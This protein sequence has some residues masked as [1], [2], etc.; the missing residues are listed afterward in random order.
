[1]KTRH[2][3][4][5]LALLVVALVVGACS[6]ATEV[7]KANEPAE[8]ELQS[9]A[10]DPTFDA[11]YNHLTPHP[12]VQPAT[13][14]QT[15]EAAVSADLLVFPRAGNDDVAAWEPGRVIV[16]GPATGARTRNPFGFARRV[17]TVTVEPERILVRTESLM[18]EDVVQGD[19]QIAVQPD[20]ARAAD[21]SNVNLDEV[22]AALYQ[23]P[24]VIAVPDDELV[25]DAPDA[26]DPYEGIGIETFGPEEGVRPQ[27]L[28][29]FWSSVKKGAQAVGKSIGG[30][31]KAVAQKAKDVWVAVTPSH[32]KG[33]VSINRELGFD[34][35]AALFELSY[36]KAFRSKSKTPFE[37]FISGSG[38]LDKASIAFNPGFQL[39]AKIPVPGHNASSQYWMN[40]DTRL[41]LELGLQMSVEAG[42]RSVDNQPVKHQNAYDLGQAG[43]EALSAAREKLLGD[44]DLKPVG[45]WKRTLYISQPRVYTFTAGPV[46]V[47]ITNTVQ[48]D[49]ECGFEVKAQ[50]NAKLS[51]RQDARFK[52]SV[53]YDGGTKRT[54]STGPTF[55]Q[56]RRFEVQVTGG[57][58]AVIACGLIPRINVFAYDTLGIFAGVRG[59]LVA[60][61]SYTEQCKQDPVKSRPDGTVKLSLA[62][63]VGLQVGA[64]IQ[65]PGSSFFGKAGQKAGTDI[66]P[67]EPWNKEWELLS[68]SWTFDGLGYCTPACKNL[69]KDAAESDVDCGGPCSQCAVGKRCRR[70][71]DCA[72]A[73]CDLGKCAV[74]TCSDG[75]RDG[76]ETDV[77][78]GGPCAKCID[79]RGCRT[80]TDCTSSFCALPAAGSGFA[81]GTCT[82]NHCTTGVQ[83]AD[84]AG[85][86]CGGRD[87]PKCPTG[88]LSRDPGACASGFWDGAYCVDSACRD[89]RL[90][91][92]EVGVDCGGVCA[93][94]CQLGQACAIDADCG[95]A[96][97]VCHGTTRTCSAEPAACR[98]GALSPGEAAVDCGAACKQRCAVESPCNVDGDCA[99]GQCHATSRTC[100]SDAC[101]NGRLD[102][103]SESDVDCGGFCPGRCNLGQRCRVDADCN[104][105]ACRAGVC[106]SPQ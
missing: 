92:G 13:T 83:D 39:G 14:K 7:P 93:A 101:S 33:E 65:A 70:N 68:K 73:T 9:F 66:G 84:E 49:L 105:A 21:L 3:V 23:D 53:N 63:N 46:P 38:S 89:R 25:D 17:L 22:I 16:A 59:S 42:V 97:P 50:L 2:A 86:D 5:I 71:S 99:S 35:N 12:W 80:G 98:D 15:E 34:Y 76:G 57:G 62:A 104:A 27:G 103:A 74:T 41:K 94:R 96:A 81:Y 44:P 24:D 102:A 18:L 4:R 37:V 64:R 11:D 26:S 30:A 67:F 72:R 1:V 58:S 43:A 69:A 61:A 78:C 10:G 36:A 90:S 28:K 29:K 88:A 6:E 60:R 100:A 40:V 95:G 77:D 54:T 20:Q 48:L 91:P 45:G 51:F 56:D 32:F 31:A 47:V 55:S 106:T 79:G 52:F 19:F 82:S 8:P 85:V 75:V 87:C